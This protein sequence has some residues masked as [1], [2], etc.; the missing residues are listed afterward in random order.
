VTTA[1]PPVGCEYETPEGRA[2]GYRARLRFTFVQQAVRGLSG[3]PVKFYAH[4]CLGHE[5]KARGS[6]VD[7]IVLESVEPL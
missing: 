4:S 2:C 7:G 6:V 1:A 3:E 5:R